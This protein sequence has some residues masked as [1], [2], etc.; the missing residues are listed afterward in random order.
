MWGEGARRVRQQR[1]RQLRQWRFVGGRE[2]HNTLIMECHA[3]IFSL[4]SL[5]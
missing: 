2:G 1:R 4:H 3:V 5:L